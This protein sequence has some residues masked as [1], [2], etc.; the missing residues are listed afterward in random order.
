M[1]GSV[2]LELLHSLSCS[3]SLLV[4]FKLSLI[5][6]QSEPPQVAVESETV[7]LKRSLQRFEQMHE[8]V[9]ILDSDSSDDEDMGR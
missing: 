1:H 7:R 4:S 9:H 8:P 2:W 5:L 3:K 6:F